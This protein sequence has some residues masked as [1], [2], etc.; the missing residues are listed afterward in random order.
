M[1][2]KLVCLCELSELIVLPVLCHPGD[3]FLGGAELVG[4]KM[5]KKKKEQKCNNSHCSVRVKPAIIPAL[6]AL[7]YMKF[8]EAK[9]IHSV[10][11]SKII[12]P[13]KTDIRLSKTDTS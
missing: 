2:N 4:S 13:L 1:Y 9:L 7:W 11:F 10:L 6:N 5:G 3:I 8:T 12:I